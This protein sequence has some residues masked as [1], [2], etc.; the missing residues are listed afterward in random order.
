MKFFAIKEE[1][2][3]NLTVCV[4]FLYFGECNGLTPNAFPSLL[5]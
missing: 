3:M 5:C 2:L 1:M 4:G